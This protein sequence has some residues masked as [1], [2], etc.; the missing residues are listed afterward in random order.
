MH[1][2]IIKEEED[3]IRHS[4]DLVWARRLLYFWNRETIYSD[5]LT[6]R[7]SNIRFRCWQYFLETGI[8]LPT[9]TIT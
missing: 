2:N 8:K 5:E 4:Q 1:S 3:I 9:N 7:E 6:R